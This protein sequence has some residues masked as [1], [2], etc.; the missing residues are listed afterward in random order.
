MNQE[1]RLERRDG[2]V[3]TPFQLGVLG[4]MIAVALCAIIAWAGVTIRDHLEGYR[5]LLAMR[6]TNAMERKEAAHALRDVSTTNAQEAIDALYH[7]LGDVDPGVRG[8][9]ALTLGVLIYRIRLNLSTAPIVADQQNLKRWSD[10]SLRR[11]VPLLHD[12]D[13]AVRAAAANGLGA[14]VR[15]LPSRKNTSQA[16]VPMIVQRQAAKTERDSIGVTLPP[17]LVAALQDRAV[18]VRVAAASAIASF[19]LDRDD[20]IAVLLGMM[21]RD[22]ATVRRAFVDALDA[23]WPTPLSVPSLRS[24]LKSRDGDVRY[25]AARLLG[26]IGPAATVAIPDL[27]TVLKEP[28][29]GRYPT[30]AHGAARAL[31][32]M[33]PDQ[34]A[35]AALMEVIAPANV[36]PGFA[37]MVQMSS[38]EAGKLAADV[39]SRGLTAVV[40]LSRVMYAMDALGEIGPPAVAAVPAMIVDYRRALEVGHFMSQTAIPNALARIAPGSAGAAE[41]VAVLIVA[42]D[43]RY[44]GIQTAAID[45]LGHFGAAAAPAIP[46]LRELAQ[47]K[48][49]DS[50]AAADCLMILDSQFRID[51][52]KTKSGR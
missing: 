27:I 42:L 9:A 47:D 6:S 2:N 18:E 51:V 24:L 12:Q 40:G 49:I 4:L 20:A 26:R 39:Q 13:Q 14:L 33:G 21:E 46:K 15:R 50:R 28:V 1:M 25:H 30:A 44:P 38:R 43:S 17:E 48:S 34:V 8:T 10:D 35:I 31:G 7:A 23:A 36:E 29:N 45:A 32:Q 16:E 52:S 11:L 5:P 41:V 37:A 22:N 3:K 19:G